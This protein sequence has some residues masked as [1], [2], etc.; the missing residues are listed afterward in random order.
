MAFWW[1]QYETIW[2]CRHTSV[3]LIF[4]TWTKR[5]P[6]VIL[7]TYNDSLT[8]NVGPCWDDSPKKTHDSTWFQGSGEQWSRYNLPRNIL[9]NRFPN[10]IH[11]V[12]P[13]SPAPQKFLRLV[14]RLMAYSL[15]I[16]KKQRTWPVFFLGFTSWF[17]RIYDGYLPVVSH[18]CELEARGQL[19]HDLWFALEHCISGPNFQEDT[20]LVYIYTYIHIIHKT[21]CVYIYIRTYFGM[22]QLLNSQGLK[23]QFPWKVAVKSARDTIPW[24]KPHFSPV[25]CTFW[26]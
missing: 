8:W 5:G 7:Q 15:E 20:E 12:S 9:P 18:F 3:I 2:Q 11:K 26:L 23:Q 6:Q 21:V 16:K 10:K 4:Q 14:W 25:K 22:Q 13:V 24:R 1:F 19:T 17:C